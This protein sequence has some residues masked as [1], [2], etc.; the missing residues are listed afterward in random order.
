M[1]FPLIVVA[2]L[3]AGSGKVGT[4]QWNLPPFIQRPGRASSDEMVCMDAETSM[5]R[6]DTPPFSWDHVTPAGT[7]AYGFD[8]Y[9]I[10][11]LLI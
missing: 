10:I 1:L 5:P 9:H 11:F 3:T 2:C 6:R 4:G 7:G 8:C